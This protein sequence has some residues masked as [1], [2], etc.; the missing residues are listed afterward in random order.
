MTNKKKLNKKPFMSDIAQ[1]ALGAMQ[2]SQTTILALISGQLKAAGYVVE[3][4]KET[5]VFLFEARSPIHDKCVQQL[6]RLLGKDVIM[7]PVGEAP[8][9]L[10]KPAEDPK[11]D[12]AVP[13]PDAVPEGDDPE[14]DDEEKPEEETPDVESPTAPLPAA[15]HGYDANGAPA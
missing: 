3:K 5:S 10:Q 9:T 1:Q 8:I 13:P 2:I 4:E 12:E 11:P 7:F 14:D 15:A 6:S